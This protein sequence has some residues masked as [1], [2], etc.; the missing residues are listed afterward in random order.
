MV[1]PYLEYRS[2]DDRNEFEHPRAY[3]TVAEAFVSP[4]KADICNDRDRFSHAEH[5]SIYQ[6]TADD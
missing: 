5:C 4:V 3:C 1:C 6:G 2:H